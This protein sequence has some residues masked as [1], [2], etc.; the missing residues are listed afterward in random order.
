MLGTRRPHISTAV[1]GL[2][3]AG[4]IRNGRGQINILDRDGLSK[5]ACTC[6]LNSKVNFDHLFGA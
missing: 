1:N 5:V 3:K 6:Y 4:L 2:H